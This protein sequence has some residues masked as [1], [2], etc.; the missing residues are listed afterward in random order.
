[1]LFP[2]ELFSKVIVDGLHP[3]ESDMVKSAITWGRRVMVL[4]IE[5]MQPSGLITLNARI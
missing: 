2:V 5:S 1:M 4:F 3:A